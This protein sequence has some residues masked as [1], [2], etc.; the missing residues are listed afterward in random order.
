MVSTQFFYDK[1][2][3]NNESALLLKTLQTMD[4]RGQNSLIEET[5]AT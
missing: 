4:Q 1:Q 5:F 3:G 2:Q